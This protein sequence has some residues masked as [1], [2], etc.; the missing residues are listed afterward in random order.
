MKVFVNNSRP[1][2]KDILYFGAWPD[3]SPSRKML[4]LVRLGQTRLGSVRFF[5]DGELSHGKET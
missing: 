5:F 3:Y 2:H 4:V 1:T